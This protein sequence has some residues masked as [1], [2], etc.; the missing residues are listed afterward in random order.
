[1]RKDLGLAADAAKDA[2]VPLPTGGVA[3]N[4]Y[5]LMCQVDMGGKDFSSVYKLLSQDEDA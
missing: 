2:G 3:F 5:S 1:M 4:L